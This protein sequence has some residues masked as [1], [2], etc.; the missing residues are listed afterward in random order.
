[1]KSKKEKGD[2]RARAEALIA[3]RPS[4]APV[5]TRTYNE[6]LHELLVHQIELEMQNEELRSAR[7][8]IE[9]SRTRYADLYDFAPVAYLTFDEHGRVMEANLTACGL[10]GVDRRTIL[11]KFFPRFVAPDDQDT[12]FTHRSE[13][14]K[15]GAK[16][17]CEL[18]LQRPDGSMFY[19]S[20]ESIEAKNDKGPTIR[21]ALIDISERKRMERER[22][23]ME[24][25]MR[26]GAAELQ[27]S[28]EKL[29]K[30][31]RGRERAEAQ[32]R[33]AQ[34]MEALGVMSGGVAHD[35]NNILAA[36]IG[37]TELVAA[38]A[39]NGA[40]DQH[41]LARIMQ[42][43]IRGRE[44]VRQMLTFSRKGE[45]EKKPLRLSN[46]VRETVSLIRGVLPT[47]V[48]I[49]VKTLSE[50]GPILADPTQIQ[51]VLINLCTNAAQAMHKKGGTLDIELSDL[52]VSPSNGDV[53]AMEPG[54]YMKLVVSDTG[55]G[56]PP[57]IMDRIFDPFF[58]TKKVG[59]GTGLGLSVVHGIVKQSN[60][61]IFVESKPDKG[62]AFTIYL[63][64][65]S[66]DLEAATIRDDALPTGS[67]RILFVDDE[68]ALVEMG[69]EI[70]AEL[71]Y[72]VTSRMNGHEAFALLKEDPSRF[73]LVVTDQTMPEITGIELARKIIAI[74][75]DMPVI[76]CT[77]YSQLVDADK[78][79]AAGIKAFVMKPLTRREIA[80]TIRKV[81]DGSQ[82]RSAA[83]V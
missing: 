54:P 26:E 6:V 80:G 30:E 83:F 36:I 41:Y 8:V 79:R 63:P 19:V 16:Q 55:I 62:S 74:R 56:M 78:A 60:G 35:F 38:H 59:E 24:R 51:Q 18:A 50:S 11:G 58:T 9:E 65:I 27:R 44:L 32:L 71:G 75:P 29:K 76:I 1:M 22:D 21:S 48:A 46:I 43:G 61:Y 20:V 2:L 47:T 10:L 52:I 28:Y 15:A 42:A 7:D 25:R 53:H 72:E 13:V 12:F 3:G 67:E 5:D 82:G 34:K 64:M 39:A 77:G 68:E 73:D 70:L 31:I 69:E 23:A 66:G 57:D 40:K 4:G 14:L 49:C 33:Q 45:Q 37:F 81:L 17:T